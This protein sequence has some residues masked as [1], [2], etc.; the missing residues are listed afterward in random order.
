MGVNLTPL[1]PTGRRRFLLVG[2]GTE[3]GVTGVV[4][5]L[6]VRVLEHRVPREPH[7][8][9][10]IRLIDRDHIVCRVGGVGHRVELLR[11]TWSF[12]LLGGLLNT[13]YFA[14]CQHTQNTFSANLLLAD[15]VAQMF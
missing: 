14:S 6:G 13:P 7:L 15:C 10:G 8:G 9:G 12:S 5:R 3:I 1:Q 4:R 11:E 2:A